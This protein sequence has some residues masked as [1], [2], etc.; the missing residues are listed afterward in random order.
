MTSEPALL[1]MRNKIT[2]RALDP[3]GGRFPEP[4]GNPWARPEAPQSSGKLN[5]TE[6]GRY[7]LSGRR[8]R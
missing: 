1:H 5:V 2:G 3:E 6:R 7:R 8:T 4:S